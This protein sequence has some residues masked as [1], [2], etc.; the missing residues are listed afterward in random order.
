[1]NPEESEPASVPP[2][3]SRAAKPTDQP[4]EAK[5]PGAPEKITGEKTLLHEASGL[6]IK[7]SVEA[8]SQP[9]KP[10]GE[11]E[12][13]S[14]PTDKK[15][16]AAKKDQKPP[17]FKRPVFIVIASVIFLTLLAGG[18]I[19]WLI[20]HQFVSTDDA[21]IDGH[22]IQVSPR[23]SA[24]V[25]VLHVQDNQFVHA[26]D[27]LLELD[28]TDYQVALDQAKA[29]VLAAQGR[30]VQ[31]EAQIG[32]AKAAVQEAVAEVDAA[33]V[34]LD[35]TSK[36]LK[37]YQE[38]DERA[39]S[40]QQLDNADAA[41]K[42]AQAQLKNTQA[43]KVSAEAE[44]T[45]AEALAVAAQGEFKTAEA[46]QKRAEVNLSYCKI[47]APTD[48]RVTERTVETGNYVAVGQAL[49]LLADPR[50]WVTAN[51]KETQLANMRKDQPVTISV[52]AFPGIKW[53]G[54]VDSIQAGSGSR[55]SVLPAENAMGN[56]VKIVQRVPVKI[57]FD[58][59]VNT[60]DTRMLSPGLSVIP[61]VK[62]R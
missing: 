2:D 59:P 26:G 45:S 3:A 55:F 52:D 57:L 15:G 10:A 9:A 36:D 18:I 4:D 7:I 43:H 47:Y 25:M 27:L 8:G 62:V 44:V 21:Y 58:D 22:V 61:R 46:N 60:N 1:M 28:P 40:Q 51:F 54:H 39:R 17:L 31:A 6:A 48:G 38:V 20:L 35:N 42:N 50:V 32:T 29:Q 34:Q 56:Y 23:A 14:Q 30:M 37:R 24:Q 11:E 13:E 19:L 33:Q 41:Q 12:K 53:H 5:L 16:A 49:L